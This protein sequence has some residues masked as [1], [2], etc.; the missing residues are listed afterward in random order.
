MKPEF[1]S[2]NWS[3]VGAS[4]ATAKLTLK[5]DHLSGGAGHDDIHIDETEQAREVIHP[6]PNAFTTSPLFEPQLTDRC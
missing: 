3:K 5:P 6:H 1:S 4:S 2:Q